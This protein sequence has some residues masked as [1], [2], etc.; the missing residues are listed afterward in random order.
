M[1]T[2]KF[3]YLKPLFETT[4]KDIFSVSRWVFSA[5][6]SSQL[7]PELKMYVLRGTFPSGRPGHAADTMADM[8]GTR[9]GIFWPY[10]VEIFPIGLKNRHYI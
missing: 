10:V 2:L 1:L 4:F 6:N 3:Q 9:F 5:M 7:R 8:D